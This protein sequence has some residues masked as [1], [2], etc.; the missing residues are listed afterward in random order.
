MVNFADGREDPTAEVDDYAEDLLFDYPSDWDEEIDE[1]GEEV[2]N[3]IDDLQKYIKLGAVR[4]TNFLEEDEVA[5]DQSSE[6][7]ATGSKRGDSNTF[8]GRIIS[9]PNWVQ[10]K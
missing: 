9:F 3:S 8:T 10:V 5:S 4:T 6:P 2:S 7:K 1:D